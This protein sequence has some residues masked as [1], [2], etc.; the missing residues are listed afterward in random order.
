MVRT[1]EGVSAEARRPDRLLADEV[2][3]VAVAERVAHVPEELELGCL[4]EVLLLRES[5]TY[6][7]EDHEQT[8]ADLQPVERSVPHRGRE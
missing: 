7:R 1:C 8:K 2:K 4:V 5:V 3:L 6:E